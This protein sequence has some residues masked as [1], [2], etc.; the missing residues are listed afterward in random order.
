MVRSQS[1]TA[2]W[3]SWAISNSSSMSLDHLYKGRT[4]SSP[5]ELHSDSGRWMK[6]VSPHDI[7]K[8]IS[9]FDVIVFNG[10]PRS[11][12]IRL[13][14]SR[15]GHRTFKWHIVTLQKFSTSPSE[16]DQHLRTEQYF[17]HLQTGYWLVWLPLLFEMVI[18]TQ[19][20][21]RAECDQNKCTTL[22]LGPLGKWALA[23]KKTERDWSTINVCQRVARGLLNIVRGLIL[24]LTDFQQLWI[25]R[26]H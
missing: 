19:R 22:P 12:W 5:N 18:C 26:W 3:W 24:T 21:L 4:S 23:R 10:C 6:T 1:G 17:P 16:K 7:K 9:S 11:P 8:G 14:F 25:K 13:L 15:T 2:V 20:L